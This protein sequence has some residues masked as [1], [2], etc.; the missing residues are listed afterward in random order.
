MQVR[1][2]THVQPWQRHSGSKPALLPPPP[3]T[4]IQQPGPLLLARRLRAPG[5]GVHT[6]M[7]YVSKA[8]PT[9]GAGR[10]AAGGWAH[11][12]PH[13]SP[14]GRSCELG[15]QGANIGGDPLQPIGLAHL[16]N[17]AL[18][19]PDGGP[20]SWDG[21]NCSGIGRGW[22]G[23]LLLC[24]AAL[25]SIG[26]RRP[27]FQLRQRAAD[28]QVLQLCIPWPCPDSSTPRWGNFR[29]RFL[30]H[31]P[32]TC[33]ASLSHTCLGLSSAFSPPTMLYPTHPSPL[34]HQK[35]STHA[36]PPPVPARA[37]S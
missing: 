2:S 29:R 12:P 35:N 18:H 37:S 6:F 1:A 25:R 9:P 28:R 10:R 3:P 20:R 7:H 30:C 32:N 19:L 21:V 5:C 15:L 36:T 27:G 16:V 33:R 14:S 22:A 13:S 11:S 4:S 24:C 26:S 34:P 17:V 23:T 8:A 31:S